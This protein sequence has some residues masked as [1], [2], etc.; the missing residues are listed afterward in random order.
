MEK[1]YILLDWLGFFY[2][3]EPLP[4]RWY[5]GKVNCAMEH[6]LVIQTVLYRHAVDLYNRFSGIFKGSL[7]LRMP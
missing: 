5:L 6:Q 2:N 4:E 1:H 3:L 7:P